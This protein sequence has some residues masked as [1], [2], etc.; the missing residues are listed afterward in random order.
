VSG[1]ALLRSRSS[2][3]VRRR[4]A[5]GGGVEEGG[6][7]GS[8]EKAKIRESLLSFSPFLFSLPESTALSF[9]LHRPLCHFSSKKGLRLKSPSPPLS[10]PLSSFLFFLSCPTSFTN[11]PAAPPN[12]IAS[13]KVP[14]RSAAALSLPLA[15]LKHT[16]DDTPSLVLPP[17]RP[18]RR[19][20]RSVGTD[21]RGSGC[22]LEAAGGRGE[23]GPT[24]SSSNDSPTLT[25]LVERCRQALQRRTTRP[26]NQL[27]CPSHPS[28]LSPS[29]P[30]PP[31]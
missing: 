5:T 2:R 14:P 9:S 26:S 3:C 24:A 15:R 10:F 29:P 25:S 13:R 7:E 6:R 4:C 18:R 12:L 28:F 16:T 30:H 21:Q 8:V 20:P 22:V 23:G 27:C 11:P 1:L 31:N 17:S 19:V